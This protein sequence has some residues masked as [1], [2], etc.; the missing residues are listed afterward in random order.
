MKPFIERTEDHHLYTTWADI[1]WHNVEENVR[2]LQERIYRATMHKA[3]RRVNNLQKL[4]VRA[5]S[6][7]LLAIPAVLH[8]KTRGNTPQGLT[9]W[10]TT[11]QKP[12]GS[13]FK[14]A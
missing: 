5:T 4:L 2:R 14:R 7:K 9:G 10:C 13:C 8:R 1:N 6:N 11:P 12:G 3:W